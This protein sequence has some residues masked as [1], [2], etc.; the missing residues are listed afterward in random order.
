VRP[1]AR[2]NPNP[3]IPTGDPRHRFGIRNGKQSSEI[4]AKDPE[5]RFELGL[6]PI[7]VDHNAHYEE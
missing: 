6:R 7:E 4:Y 2:K 5:R 3:S 1:V